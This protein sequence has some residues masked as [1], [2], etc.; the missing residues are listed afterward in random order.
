MMMRM[1][2]LLTDTEKR[3]ALLGNNNDDTQQPDLDDAPTFVLLEHK[4]VDRSVIKMDNITDWHR[5]ESH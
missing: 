5:H 1:L 2:S 3:D 4:N